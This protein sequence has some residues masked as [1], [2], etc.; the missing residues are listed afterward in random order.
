MSGGHTTRK[1]WSYVTIM[2]VIR[3]DTG[4]LE[5]VF[6]HNAGVKRHDLG[7]NCYF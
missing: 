1:R 2:V 4:V 7:R 6:I 5:G 3:H